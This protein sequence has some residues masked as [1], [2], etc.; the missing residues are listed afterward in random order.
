MAESNDFVNPIDP[1]KVAENPGLLPYAHHVASALIRPEDMGK[2]KVRALTA[3]EEQTNL[4]L[5]QIQEQI[6]LLAKQAM[7]IKKRAEIS[8]KIY[9]AKMGFEPVIGKIYY[10]YKNY[11]NEEYVLSMIAPN[12]WGKSKTFDE[13]V[14]KVKM[15]GDHTWQIFE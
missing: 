7:D 11:S 1:D 8:Y 5:K 9:G 13:F 2:V 4:Q 6:E 14:S 10:L 15:L 12:E 3:M